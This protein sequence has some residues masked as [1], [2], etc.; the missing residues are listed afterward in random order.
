[1]FLGV[2]A[3]AFGAHGLKNVLPDPMKAIFET[4]V[5]YQVIHGLALLGV[6]WQASR[7]TAGTVNA[8][9]WFFTAGI[10]LFSGSLY[11]LSVTGVKT[12]GA[13]TPFGGLAFLLGWLCLALKPL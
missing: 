3:G 10:V 8:A 7:N 2:A 6:A 13:V 9:G 4:A 12:W 11:I 1:M 5:R